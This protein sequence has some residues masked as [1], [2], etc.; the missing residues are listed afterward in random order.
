ML[1]TSSSTT[2]MRRPS[3]AASRS[4][5][6]LQHALA[7]GRQLGLDLVQE[8]RDLVEQPLGRARALDDDRLRVAAQPLLLVARQ[9]A[10]G[11]DDD[12]RERVRRPARPSAR[13]ARSRC[14]SGSVRSI[15]MQSKVVAAQLLERL[16]G[17]RRRATI[18]TS[19]VAEQ[20]ADALA[21]ARVVLDDQ[22]AA[23]PL[24]ELAPRAAGAPRPA[25]SRLTGFSA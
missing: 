16:G 24:R 9:R 23:Q 17:G 19:S 25:R 4:R 5:A 8:Q 21:L 1:R 14:T 6:A 2:R 22:H 20:L 12:R 7:L 3:S 15:T 11:V 18:S 13:A 10:A